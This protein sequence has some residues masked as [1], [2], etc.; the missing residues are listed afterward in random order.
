MTRTKAR[1]KAG[2]KAGS[3]N[4]IASGSNRALPAFPGGLRASGFKVQEF[5][6]PTFRI[7][8]FR[9]S[10]FQGWGGRSALGFCAKLPS[11]DV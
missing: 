4:Q 8:D 7:L 6:I 10:G 11:M 9:V 2:E 3:G 1:A 5:R